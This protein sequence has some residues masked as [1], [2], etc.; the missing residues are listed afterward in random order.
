MMTPILQVGDF[1]W[2]QLRTVLLLWVPMFM[3]GAQVKAT[4]SIGLI[5]L[6]QFLTT[7]IMMMEPKVLYCGGYQD[8]PKVHREIVNDNMKI[9]NISRFSNSLFCHPSCIFRQD[10]LK[11]YKDYFPNMPKYFGNVSDMV[12]VVSC[13]SLNLTYIPPGCPDVHSPSFLR[14]QQFHQGGG[15]R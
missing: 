12:S 13:M 11:R 5:L 15:P 8:C 9:I 2:W 10:S 7:D 14:D 3:C 1:G 4:A 6:S